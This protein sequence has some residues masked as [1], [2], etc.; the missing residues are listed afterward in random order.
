MD[1]IDPVIARASGPALD[2]AGMLLPADFTSHHAARHP[3]RT[4]LIFRD[5]HWSYAEL[6]RACD[7]AVSILRGFG[8]VAGDRIAYLGKNNDLY[9]PFLIGAIRAGLVTVPI[10]WRNTAVETRYVLEDSGARLVLADAEFVPSLPSGETPHRPLIVTDDDG[11][12]GLRARIAAAAPAPRQ[13]LDEHAPSLQLYT[14]GTTGKP[15]GVLTSQ[16]ALGAQRHIEIVS[17]AFEDWAD[18]EILLSPLPMFHIGGMSWVMTALVRGQTVVVTD[19]TSPAAILERC[20]AHAVT[21]TFLV[22]TLVRGL[23][24][25]MTASGVPV[26][27]LRG[28]HYGAASMSPALLERSVASLGCRFL[29]YYGMTEVTGSITTLS[30]QDHDLAR[31]HLLRSVGKVLAGFTVDIR[32][33][34]KQPLAIGQPGEIWVQGPSLLIEYWNRPDATAEALE[35]GWYRSGDGGMLDAEGFLYLTDRI[36]DMIVSGGE[37]VYP[38]EV[39]AVLREHPAVLDCA[40]FGLPHPKW[41]EG[42]VAAIELRPGQT[43]DVELLIAFARLS[44]AAYKIPRR[45]EI[46]VS[47]PRTA[48]GK[49]QRGRVRERYLSPPSSG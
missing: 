10:N 22:P 8:L 30:P 24:E 26:T 14:S 13:T 21:R 49:I 32:G 25:E 28:I 2:L 44:L 47:L 46:G 43:A 37:N 36:K 9:F 29:Q 23:I 12:D 15:K 45:M 1:R 40:V 4:A 7:A 34:D 18:D 19:N 3:D 39:E 41:G 35:D 48:S 20:L 31:P 27:T 38:A 17:A 16:H 5:R 42:V 6:D 33:P 11:P